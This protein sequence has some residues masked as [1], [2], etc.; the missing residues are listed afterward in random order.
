MSIVCH[1]FKS[2]SQSYKLVMNNEQK[3]KKNNFFG[4]LSNT[5]KR[6][7]KTSAVKLS[8]FSAEV[9]QLNTFSLQSILVLCNRLKLKYVEFMLF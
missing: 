8:N 7:L 3:A 9:G 1:Y 6:T 4:V 2:T 5:H